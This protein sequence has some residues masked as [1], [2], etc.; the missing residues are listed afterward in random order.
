MPLPICMTKEIP[1][2]AGDE[3]AFPVSQITRE[4]LLYLRPDLKDEIA[5][6]SPSD[7]Q[8]L[9]DKI[10]DGLQDAYWDVVG[11]VLDRYFPERDEDADAPDDTPR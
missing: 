4:D 1:T 6:L 5:A 7:M 2:G 3:Q 10:G 8:R 9:A 11:I